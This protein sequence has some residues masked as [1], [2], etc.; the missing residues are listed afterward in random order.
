VVYPLFIRFLPS[1]VVKEFHP[2]IL[3]Y[4]CTD[5]LLWHYVAILWHDLAWFCFLGNGWNCSDM[6]HP[7]NVL[8]ELHSPHHSQTKPCQSKRFAAFP[9]IPLS[10]NI[11]TMDHDAIP[12][13]AHGT[14]MVWRNKNFRRCTA[15][16]CHLLDR[17]GPAPLGRPATRSGDLRHCLGSV[18]SGAAV[19]EGLG[20]S[21]WTAAAWDP[22]VVCCDQLGHGL[23]RALL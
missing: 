12:E 7:P 8:I 6:P 5:K 14:M 22:S 10:W 17:P 3:I 9:R 21:G 23:L 4:R 13:V 20:T 18:G 19:A 15:E 11:R 16:L 2:H 1:N